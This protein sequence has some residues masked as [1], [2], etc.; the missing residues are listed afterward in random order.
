MRILLHRANGDTAP[1]IEAFATALPAAEVV[2]WRDGADPEPC[3]YAVMWSP[4]VALLPHL[5]KVKAIFVTGAGVDGVMRFADE[6]KGVPVVR[7]ADAGMADQMAEYVTWA[8]LR[9]FRRLDEYAAQ[10]R[11][12]CWQQLPRFERADF[13]VGI[14]GLGVLG[15]RVAESLRR[16]GFPLR[17]WNRTQRTVEG[18]ECF[19]GTDALAPFLA[20]TRALVCL[21]PLTPETAGLLDRAR[22]AQL[23]RGAYFINVGR[24]AHVAD[25]DLLM[26]VQSGQL[27]GATLDVFRNEPLP[28]QHPFWGEPRIMITPHI[29]A[30]TLVPESAQQMAAKMRAFEDNEPVQ[31]IVDPSRGY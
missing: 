19:A 26:A 8:V 3:D 22:L 1:W 27:A 16:L 25:A 15:T 5:R 9:Y 2:V 13:T 29:A 20:G 12:R 14:L 10:A 11:A 23:P 6:L 18:I 17:A 24:G 30:A 21:L 4:T 7:L 28:A 31:D